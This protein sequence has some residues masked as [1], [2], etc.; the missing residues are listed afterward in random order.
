MH[1]AIDM[2]DSVYSFTFF[3]KDIFKVFKRIREQ[4]LVLAIVSGI[5]PRQ[6]WEGCIIYAGQGPLDDDAT[7]CIGTRGPCADEVQQV[8][9]EELERL[10]IGVLQVYEGGPEIDT[11]FVRATSTGWESAT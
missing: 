2:T 6:D 11:L 5:K 3:R 9:V 7:V 8:L 1:Y 4:E 10:G